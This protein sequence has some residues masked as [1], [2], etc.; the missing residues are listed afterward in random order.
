M[1]KKKKLAI[2]Y[3]L[4][5]IMILTTLFFGIKYIENIYKEKVTDNNLKKINNIELKEKE[6]NNDISNYED[7]YSK[8]QEYYNNP[9]I[10]GT[11]KVSN[12]IDTKIVQTTDNKY[13]L[14]HLINREYGIVGSVF[15][16]YKSDIE[17]GRQ[18]N[19]YGHNSKDYDVPFKSLMNYL[20]KDFFL[21]NK[22]ITLE[23]KTGIRNFEIFSVK[24]ITTDIEH[25]KV[26]FDDDA[27]FNEHITKLRANSLYD[28]NLSIKPND[29]VLILQTCITGSSPKSYLIVSA[30]K[31]QEEPK[32]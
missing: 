28:S 26:L 20:D 1:S 21:N 17:N 2:Y 8:Y 25:T 15:V 12:I 22:Y 14:T 29:Q 19:I 4:I 5:I 16:D 3:G 10:I 24:I 27:S 11:L 18:I 32:L 23:T 13:Y 6:K 9:D 31:I 30:K 7:K